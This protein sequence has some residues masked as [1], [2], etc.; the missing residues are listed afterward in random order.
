MRRLAVSLVVIQI[1]VKRHANIAQEGAAADEEF[2]QEDWLR[3]LRQAAEE[4][5][6]S[7]L[8]EGALQKAVMVA[9]IWV[10]VRARKKEREK[11]G[12]TQSS[13]GKAS[14]PQHEKGRGKAN[15]HKLSKSRRGKGKGWWLLSSPPL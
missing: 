11:E 8:D 6:R 7:G 9:K 4:G 15:K 12:G 10:R 2:G 3:G 5:R 13:V 14:S 1:S